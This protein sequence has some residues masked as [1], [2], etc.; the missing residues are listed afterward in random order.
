M[1]KFITGKIDVYKTY[2]V[3]GKTTLGQITPKAALE[4]YVGTRERY[5]LQT[6]VI[7]TMQG[8]MHL[9]RKGDGNAKY[10]IDIDMEKLLKDKPE[11]VAKF[12]VNTTVKKRSFLDKVGTTMGDRTAKD[13]T[14]AELALRLALI[15]EYNE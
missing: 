3:Y 6:M 15:K 8:G 13:I 2:D 10:I 7:E 11:L 5:N 12:K 4:G 1:E 14:P 9:V